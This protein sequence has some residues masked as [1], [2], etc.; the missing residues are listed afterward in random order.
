MKSKIARRLL[1]YFGTALILFALV[2]GGIFVVLFRQSAVQLN[3]DAL[4]QRAEA[5]ASALSG[6]ASGGSGGMGMRSGYGAYLKLL[7][8]IA[9]TDVWIV[10][11]DLNLLTAGMMGTQYAYGD[12]P[13]DASDGYRPPSLPAST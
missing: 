3:R 2:M 13:S 10:D 11:R 5:M 7:D 1:Q 4:R 9:M 12:L 6:Y 8:E